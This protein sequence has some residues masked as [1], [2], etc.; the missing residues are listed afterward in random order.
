MISISKRQVEVQLLITEQFRA[1]E[2]CYTSLLQ[3][4]NVQQVEWGLP[5]D[6][7]PPTISMQT[8]SNR[9]CLQL[10]PKNAV[11]NISHKGRA[12]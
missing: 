4:S 3:H 12:D 5:V 2:R 7:R 6:S 8:V 1:D 10:S 9:C 11:V